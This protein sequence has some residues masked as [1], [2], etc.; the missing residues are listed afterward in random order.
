VK[1]LKELEEGRK[2]FK[3]ELLKIGDMRRGSVTEQ[4]IPVLHKGKDK[5]V[6]RG[7]YYVYTTKIGGKSVGRHLRA[8]ELKKYHMEVDN[9]HKFQEVCKKLLNISEEICGLKSAMMESDIDGIKKSLMKSQ[10]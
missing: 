3:K 2:M 10:R 1:E 8:A 7:P 4:Y 9:F 5:P 6:L